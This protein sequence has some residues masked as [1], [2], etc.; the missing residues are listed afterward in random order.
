MNASKTSK[1]NSSAKFSLT[2]AKAQALRKKLGLNQHDFW[3][4][5][6]VGQASASRYENGRKIPRPTQRLYFLT[7]HTQGLP[8][9]LSPVE[10]RQYYSI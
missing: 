5:L 6:G 3:A 4:L 7:F 9:L 2:G 8:G 10:R 1:T